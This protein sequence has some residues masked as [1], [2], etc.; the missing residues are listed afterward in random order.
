L[1]FLFLRHNHFAYFNAWFVGTVTVSTL[2]LWWRRRAH[3]YVGD[4]RISWLKFNLISLC[5]LSVKAVLWSYISVGLFSDISVQQQSFIV[6]MITGV[7][8]GSI[9]VNASSRLHSQATLP[10]LLAPLIWAAYRAGSEYGDLL[11]MAVMVYLLVLLK[12]SHALSMTLKREFETSEHNDSLRR[13]LEE[14]TASLVTQAQHASLGE[15]AGNMAHEINN[16]LTTLTANIDLLKMR[17]EQKSLK[18]E[19]VDS[20]IEKMQSNIHRVTKII[21]G[22]RH[23]SRPTTFDE[24]VPV[25]MNAIFNQTSLLCHERLEAEG[26]TLIVRSCTENL[27]IECR[28]SEICHAL[29]NLIQNSRDAIDGL[30]EKWI[31]ME[32]RELIDAVE[33]RITDSGEGI[34]E[35]LSDKIMEPF[36]TTK[37]VGKGVGLGL[38]VAMAIVQ[39]HSGT[40]ELDRA[41]RNT[42]FVI[43]LPIKMYNKRLLDQSA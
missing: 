14:K 16:P 9:S 7:A 26:I 15:M 2:S 10:A 43:R 25:K 23:F 36:F 33:I 42:S 32:A 34:P 22:L 29:L 21:K 8:A 35:P 11:S 27:A 28:S 31:R 24:F 19:Q 5:I 18:R 38:S 1:I 20:I 17:L 37:D 30:E 4:G 39:A 13:Q 3:I 6:M 40:L 12:V 41:S